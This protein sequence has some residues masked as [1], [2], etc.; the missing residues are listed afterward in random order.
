MQKFVIAG[1]PCAGKSTTIELLEDAG[2]STLHET[3][4]PIIDKYRAEHNGTIP[5]KTKDGKSFQHLTLYEQLKQESALSP[6]GIYFLDGA[7]PDRVAICEHE[8]VTVPP[9]IKQQ[10]ENQTYT[11]VFLLEQLPCELYKPD[12]HRPNSVSNS[13][14]IG[15][16]IEKYYSTSKFPLVKIPFTTPKKRLQLILKEVLK[17]D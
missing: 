9:D 4:K 2:Y 14:T 13:R 17:N 7:L 11:K 3:S 12:S 8:R 6:C 15:K 16:V 1:G 5:W 10:L